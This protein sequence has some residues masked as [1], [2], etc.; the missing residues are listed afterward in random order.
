MHLYII[1]LVAFTGL[2]H[3][4]GGLSASSLDEYCFYSIYQSLSTLTWSGPHSQNAACN[5]PVQVS[6]IYTSAELYCSDE[7][8]SAGL[9]KDQA[10]PKSTRLSWSVMGYWGGILLIGILHRLW[11]SSRHVQGGSGRGDV[12]RKREQ[13][14]P[15]KAGIRGRLSFYWKAY[16]A[17]PAALGSYH[18]RRLLG[19]SIPNRPE[20]LVV[21]GFWIMCII[22]NFGFH[23]I[24]IP[25]VTMPTISQQAWKYVAQR[26]SMFAYA[27]LPWV[28][29]FAGRNNIFIWATGWSFST[30][31]VFHRHLSRLTA[32]FAFVHAI[33]YTV[34]D[35]IY[36]P[37]YEEGLH[38]LWFKFGIIGAI[39]M[40]LLCGLSIFYIRTKC[41]ELFLVGH[42]LFAVILLVALFQCVLL[43]SLPVY[44]FG[45]C[46]TGLQ[47]KTDILPFSEL[48][49]TPTSGQWL[50]YG[51]VIGSCASYASYIATSASLPLDICK[52]L[53]QC[54]RGWENHPFTV[55]AYTAPNPTS[56][57]TS[58]SNAQ[59]GPHYMT[60]ALKEK[61]PFTS[62]TTEIFTQETRSSTTDSALGNLVF[63]I[64]PYN[65]WTK[66]LKDQCLSLSSS[67]DSAVNGCYQTSIPISLEGPYGHTLPLHHYGTVVMI[68]GGTGIATAVPYIHDHVSRSSKTGSRVSDDTKTQTSNLTLVWTCRGHV[69]ME[70]LCGRELAGALE[71]EGFTGRFHCTKGCNSHCAA[72]NKNGELRIERGRPNIENIIHGAATEAQI[73]RH[74]MA[75]LTC[76][77]PHMSDEEVDAVICLYLGEWWSEPANSTWG[78]G[79]WA[80]VWGYNFEVGNVFS[81]DKEGYNVNGETFITLGVEGSYVPVT[82][83]VTSMHGMLWASGNILKPDG[84]NVT[85]EPTMAGVLDW[86]TSS[87]AAAGKVLPATSQASEKSGAP[88]CFISYR[89]GSWR[90]ENSENSCL[91]LETMGIKIA[92]ETY[93]AMTNKTSFT[94]PKRTL[95][96]AGAVPFEQSPTTKFFVLN[97]QLS[98]PKSARDSGVQ[99]GFKILSSE[100]ESTTIY[101]QFSNE[102]IIIDRRRLRLFDIN[103]NCKDDSKDTSDGDDK[104]E[105]RKKKDAYREHGR[106]RHN[107]KLAAEDE[108]HIETL[109]LTIVVA[110]AVLEVYA[111]SRFALSTWARTWYAN[112]TEI[113]FFHNGE[114]EVTFSDIGVSDGLYDAYPDRAR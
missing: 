18:Q 72:D 19:C 50:P 103:K 23:D 111:N 22:L 16:I 92:R 56:P 108:S 91:R 14:L 88:D 31:N 68:V 84:G 67:D 1:T 35:T 79:D 7:E 9:A 57:I 114:G 89:T 25:N 34:L 48:N 15:D 47:D 45:R 54:W 90:V 32:I 52:Q 109:D 102:S 106:D 71:I 97:A 33:S 40:G 104:Q 96:E 13:Q 113:S 87:Y 28:W 86:G 39:M 20:I 24:F 27:C 77:S 74:K 51:A 101:Y 76:G 85:F 75:V 82:E 11:T 46:E 41:Y 55:G 112:S 61:N 37:Y 81:L 110:N 107:V 69:F 10:L 2:V 66:R 64:R 63:W 44:D 17:V 36:G 60:G 93:K 94:E 38:V 105:E 4:W 21:V 6:S 8:L 83:S 95:S 78:N 80:K 29:L 65:G 43:C 5:N 26:T 70:Q 12:E 49:I 62:T 30:F 3:C 53:Q 98:L 100:L 59:Q 99:A 73:A 58:S 42:I